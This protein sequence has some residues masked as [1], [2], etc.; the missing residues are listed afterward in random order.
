MLLN[1]IM[2]KKLEK[3]MFKHRNR[4]GLYSG[5]NKQTSHLNGDD[6]HL[7]SYIFDQKNRK[8]YNSKS[9]R[10]MKLHE[11]F[12]KKEF[13]FFLHEIENEDLDEMS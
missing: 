7:D 5:G 1:P 8:N 13:E 9:N 10:K 2:L 3:H 11:E 12:R 4:V 6:R